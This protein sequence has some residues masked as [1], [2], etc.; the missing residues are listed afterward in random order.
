MWT[1]EV[2]AD[3]KN[4]AVDRLK[5]P[6][7]PGIRPRPNKRGDLRSQLSDQRTEG[8][9]LPIGYAQTL[10]NRTGPMA[11]DETF[12]L[13]DQH[14]PVGLDGARNVNWFVVANGQVDWASRHSHCIKLL[15]PRR[16]YNGTLSRLRP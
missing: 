6:D 1:A 10:L 15:A 2:A 4:F 8:L 13:C 14:H 11:D 12:L 7:K 3:I 5:L 9:S 16:E